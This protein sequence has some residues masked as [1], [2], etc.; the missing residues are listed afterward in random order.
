MINRRKP[1]EEVQCYPESAG[2]IDPG[3]GSMSGPSDGSPLPRQTRDKRDNLLT[4]DSFPARI[5]PLRTARGGRFSQT[6]PSRSFL[7]RK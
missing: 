4:I 2:D 1:Y 6:R 7:E 3:Q 5:P